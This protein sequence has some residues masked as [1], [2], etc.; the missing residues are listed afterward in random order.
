MTSLDFCEDGVS[1]FP[2]SPCLLISFGKKIDPLLRACLSLHSSQESSVLGCFYGFLPLSSASGQVSSW[3]RWMPNFLWCP[4]FKLPT[5]Y[6]RPLRA[7]SPE[8][9]LLHSWDCWQLCSCLSHEWVS[10]PAYRAV[11][12]GEWQGLGPCPCQNDTKICIKYIAELE[13]ATSAL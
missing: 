9:G 13:H 6:C 2:L 1:A 3:G 4:P 12:A 10:S 8:H 5:T 7:G 11:S